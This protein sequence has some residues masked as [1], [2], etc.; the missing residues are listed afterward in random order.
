MELEGWINKCYLNATGGKPLDSDY[1]YVRAV[2][3]I[4]EQQAEIDKYRAMLGVA[5]SVLEQEYGVHA[6]I[7]DIEE[8][9]I[10]KH[11]AGK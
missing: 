6:V 9:L 5:K 10:A 2:N 11:K 8:L 4:D 7:D 3:I 1:I